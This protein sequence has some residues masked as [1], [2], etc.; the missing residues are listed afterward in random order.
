MKG[1]KK[2]GS[3]T[4]TL[5][6]YGSAWAQSTVITTIDVYGN[7][8][9][10]SDTILFHINK[11][12]G[13]SINPASFQ[14]GPTVAALKRI[15]GVRQAT[16]NPVCCDSKNGY[17]LYIGIAESNSAIVKHR[18]APGQ[19]LQLSH[20]IIRAYRNFNQQVRAAVEMGENSE[21]YSNGYSLLTYPAARK[22]QSGFIVW[23]QQR[24]QEL[25]KVVKYSRHAEQRAAAAQI[26][27]YASDKKKVAEYLLYAIKDADEQVRNN[28]ARALSIL[29][30]YLSEHPE[31]KVTIPAAPFIEWLHSVS[32]TDRNKGAMLLEQLTRSRDTALLEQIKKQAM[33]SVI[34]MAKWKNREHAFFSFIL[35]SRIAG[36]EESLLIERNFSTN[37][38]GLVDQMVEKLLPSGNN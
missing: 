33:P 36:E 27:A 19:D 37:W 28:A 1:Y 24:F 15:P 35:L 8:K 14:P 34:E 6:I 5:I 22:E 25:A 31:L 18:P 9:I 11:K 17:M 3:A 32:W 26:I 2:I 29:A 7:R 38:P 30:G 20:D 21:E 23:A 16:V 10:S 4:L 13:D 12:E